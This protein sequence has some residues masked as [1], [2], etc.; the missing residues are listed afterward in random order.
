[1][2]LLAASARTR[3]AS[4]S[5]GR[6]V[7]SASMAVTSWVLSLQPAIRAATKLVTSASTGKRSGPEADRDGGEHRLLGGLVQPLAA[8]RV[9]QPVEIEAGRAAARL[10]GDR[11][12]ERVGHRGD[13]EQAV[14]E[15]ER[16]DGADLAHELPDRE[17]GGG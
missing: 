4:V 13:R 3:P 7:R 11:A 15:G 1:M 10:G 12:G 2:T 9:A 16:A 5:K 14:G 8:D 17:P 6:C